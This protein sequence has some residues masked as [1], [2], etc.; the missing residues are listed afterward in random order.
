M[1]SGVKAAAIYS[2]ISSDQDGTALGV[3]RQ[4]EDCRRL[5]EAQGWRVAEEYV[6]NDLSAYSGKNR[7]S[8]Q[9]MLADLR[10]G[11]RDAVIVYHVDRL[12]R[13]PIELEEFIAAVDAAKVRHVRF[14]VG[15]TDLASGDGLLVARMLGAVAAN[16]SASKSRR[17]RRKLDEVAASGMP[18]GGSNR[19][20][21]YEVDHH[22]PGRRSRYRPA[23]G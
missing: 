9:R 11:Y 19:P 2:R 8:Y 13:R 3:A 18:H 1:S 23:A 20:F 7:P 16:E 12:T 22:R 4:L 21:G 5:A 10:D 17:V 14:V 15:D 6:D